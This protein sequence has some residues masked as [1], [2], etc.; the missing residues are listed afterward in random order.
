MTK[1]LS[2]QLAD[3]STRAKKAEDAF[4]AAQKEAYDKIAARREQARAAAMA[5]TEKVNQ[6]IKSVK[7]T[8]TRNW[9]A[10]QA[11][12]TADMQSL[13][14]E[15]VQQKQKLDVRI[16]QDRAD[17]LEWEAGFA[18]DYAN[19]AVEQANLAV[20]DAIAGRVQADEL[21]KAAV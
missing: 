18:I 19:A 6:E 9:N 15:L 11:K 1:R 13:K 20:L 10:L 16:A 12:I 21:R 3:L 2:D 5:A 7:D 8:A 14:S 17:R 4:D